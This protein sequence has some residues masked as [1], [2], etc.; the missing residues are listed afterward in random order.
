MSYLCVFFLPF[1][2]IRA[3]YEYQ[4]TVRPD[5]F[6]NKHTQWY[7]FQVTNTQA[8]IAYR[9]TI[10]NFTKPSSLYNRV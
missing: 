8:E 7:Y 5:L 6:T 9:F 3:D 1:L 10:V 4:L 2:C